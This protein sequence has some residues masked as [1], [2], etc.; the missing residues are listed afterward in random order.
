MSILG[1]FW[2]YFGEDRK[3]LS[4]NG[5]FLGSSTAHANEQNF[6]FFHMRDEKVGLEWRYCN[7]NKP[8]GEQSSPDPAPD[9]QGKPARNVLLG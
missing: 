4:R 9:G 6:Y 2:G 5:L 7:G 3:S 1:I 8:K